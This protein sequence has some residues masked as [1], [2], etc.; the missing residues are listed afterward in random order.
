MFWFGFGSVSVNSLLIILLKVVVL[1][2]VKTVVYII[3]MV[4]G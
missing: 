1:T 2:F 3:D 4:E